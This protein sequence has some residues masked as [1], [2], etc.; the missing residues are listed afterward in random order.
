MLRSTKHIGV[1]VDEKGPLFVGMCGGEGPLRGEHRGGA[2]FAWRSLRQ[3]VVVVVVVVGVCLCLWHSVRV[4]VCLFVCLFVCIY[5]R[6]IMC[7]YVCVFV[8]IQANTWPAQHPDCPFA[9][10]HY[11]NT[12]L[13]LVRACRWAAVSSLL[14][15]LCNVMGIYAVKF[16]GNVGIAQGVWGESCC[17]LLLSHCGILWSPFAV[18]ADG[19]AH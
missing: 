7:V 11:P 6:V 17:R 10:H 8:C 9:L 13:P 1:L 3:C 18:Q 12:I 19:A 4:Y 14:W 2:D 16:L 5:V 15:T